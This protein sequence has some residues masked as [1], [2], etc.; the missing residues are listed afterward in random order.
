MFEMSI[1]MNKVKMKYLKE[2]I[3]IGVLFFFFF[4]VT[5]LR[6]NSILCNNKGGGGYVLDGVTTVSVYILRF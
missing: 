6:Q 4:C 2:A 3:T 1:A 5:S